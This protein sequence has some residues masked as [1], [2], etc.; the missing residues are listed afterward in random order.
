MNKPDYRDYLEYDEDECDDRIA[1]EY[2]IALKKY[3]DELEHKY[4]KLLDDIHDYRHENH[5]MK[6][7]IR[8]LCKHFGV[9]NEEELK[10]IY[11][12]KEERN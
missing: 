11:L 3:C 9:E 6:L 8:N 1:E 5:C 4:N 10:Q 2:Y 12:K 7:T